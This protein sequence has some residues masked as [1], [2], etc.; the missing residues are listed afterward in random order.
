MNV[1]FVKYVT[2]LILLGGTGTLAAF[3]SLPS[4]VV[5]FWRVVLGCLFLVGACALT[6]CPLPRRVP[7]RTWGM[8]GLAGAAMAGNW[9]ILFAA[10]RDIGVGLGIVLDYTGPAFV[11]LAAPFLFKERLTWPRVLTLGAAM[12]GVVCISSQALTTGVT[13]GGLVYAIIA[14]LF[15]AAMIITNRYLRALP[16]LWAA[17]LQFGVASVIVGAYLAG[18]GQ[19]TVQIGAAN[20]WPV[21]LLGLNTGICYFL[22]IPAVQILPVQT[23]AVCGYLEPLSSVLIS[24]VVLGQWLTPLQ[25]LGAALILGGAVWCEWQS[26]RHRA[27][28]RA[29]AAGASYARQGLK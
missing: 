5:V 4:E 14:A 26:R 20:I 2:S 13:I 21:L 9:L 12:A 10:Y 29:G 19:L 16:A 7:Y 3:I 28:Q 1:P 15:F 25:W 8:L 18:T 22:Y 27:P 23:V 6:K 24:I 17:A 11:L